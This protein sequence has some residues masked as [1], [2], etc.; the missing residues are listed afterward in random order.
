MGDVS[1]TLFGPGFGICLALFI[2]LVLCGVAYGVSV[3]RS[4]K[5]AHREAMERVRS[6]NLDDAI[7]EV[8]R[9][10]GCD[11]SWALVALCRVQLALINGEL[12]RPADSTESDVS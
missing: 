4:I 5:K 6:A 9:V 7:A 2:G 10:A 12:P 11:G 1:A 3:D 8:R